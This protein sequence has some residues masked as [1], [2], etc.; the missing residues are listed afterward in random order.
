MPLAGPLPVEILIQSSGILAQNS[1]E[2][3]QSFYWAAS[4]DN[5]FTPERIPYFPVVGLF[6]FY[7]LGFILNCEIRYFVFF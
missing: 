6:S 5:W 7:I 3:P 1:L 4:V 2:A